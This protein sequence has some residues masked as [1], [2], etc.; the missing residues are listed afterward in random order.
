ML[1]WKLGIHE[2]VNKENQTNTEVWIWNGNFNNMSITQRVR[3]KNRRRVVR[4]LQRL[5]VWVLIEGFLIRGIFDRKNISY[6]NKQNQSSMMSIY[7][8]ESRISNLQ[9]S[10]GNVVVPGGRGNLCKSF[11]ISLSSQGSRAESSVVFQST[12]KKQEIT[13]DDWF[14]NWKPNDFIWIKCKTSFCSAHRNRTISIYA[15]AFGRII[16][17][18]IAGIMLVIP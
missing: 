1:F 3:R 15:S 16:S 10:R 11:S 2:A 18:R 4:D 13:M 5:L 12:D 7:F 17:A 8:D 6:S 14:Q 9:I